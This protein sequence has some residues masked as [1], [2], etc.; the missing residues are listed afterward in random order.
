MVLVKVKTRWIALLLLAFI[1][2]SFSLRVI[3]PYD[4]VFG[5]EW[6][7]FTSN[8]AYW[9]MEQV[10]KIAPDFPTY[11]GKIL[12][13]PFFHWL[14][15][16]TIWVVSLGNPTQH[17][18]DIVGVYFPAVLG[19]LTVIPVYFLGRI[20]F[21][22]LA[23]IV[24]ATLI[25]ILPGEWLGRSSLGF[26]DYHVLE[27]LLTTTALMFLV[28]AIKARSKSRIIYGL[29][30]GLFFSLYWLTWRGA[31]LFGVIL[32]VFLW[33]QLVNVL[34][35]RH[36]RRLTDWLAVICLFVGLDIIAIAFY[37][38]LPTIFTGPTALTTMELES[39]TLLT[40]WLNFGT[41]TFLV[42]VIFTLLAYQAVKRGEASLIL[43]LVWGVVTLVIML[44]YRRFAYYFGVNAALLTGWL[45]W[46]LWGKLSVWDLPKAIAVT[47]ILCGLVVFPNIQQATV[48]HSYHSPSAAWCDTLTWVKENTPQ[49]SLILAWWD[50]GYRISRIGQRSAYITPGQPAKRIKA[51]ARFFL[52]HNEES[53]IYFDYLI[54]DSPTITSM[55][56]GVTIWAGESVKLYSP[57]YYQSLV[58]R[59]YNGEV[60][61]QYA[62]VYQSE[63]K[64]GSIPE[65]KVFYKRKIIEGQ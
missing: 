1:A 51:T 32:G 21:G 3:P 37:R 20:M 14:L 30:V 59:L 24:A 61:G 5:S 57:R 40:A 50:Y 31:V 16:A 6:I 45:V 25:A 26:T 55:F 7:K 10:D 38:Y 4:H 29:L 27:V 2:L 65:V 19:A 15:S 60:I 56:G 22:Q 35:R 54:L 36:S 11:A 28:L 48:S 33:L 49:D 44:E 41:I 46:Y 39:L 47:A 64:I 9:Q 8:D 34:L 53:D 13:I 43:F 23:G 17:T 63:Q 42:P 62:L 12:Q 18:I 52:S 58:V